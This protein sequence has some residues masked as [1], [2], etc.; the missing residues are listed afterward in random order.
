MGGGAHLE[1]LL[2]SS[3]SRAVSAHLGGSALG[4]CPQQKSLRES[5]GQLTSIPSAAEK[6]RL[7]LGVRRGRM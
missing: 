4:G 2:M 7:G 6:L 3:G 5:S 1:K